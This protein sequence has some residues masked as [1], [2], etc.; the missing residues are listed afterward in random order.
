[1]LE[2][3]KKRRGFLTHDVVHAWSAWICFF[4]QAHKVFHPY[5]DAIFFIFFETGKFD[6]EYSKNLGSM[7]PGH[8]NALLK[9]LKKHNCCP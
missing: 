8:Q 3:K 5:V 4:L 7:E 2:M 1:M 9:E 6:F